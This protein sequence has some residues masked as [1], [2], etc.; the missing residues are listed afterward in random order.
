MGTI[1]DEVRYDIMRC[2]EMGAKYDSVIDRYSAYEDLERQKALEQE[3]EAAAAAELER[4]KEL[5]RQAE[6]KR[7]AEERSRKEYE[8]LWNRA[9]SGFA[10]SIGRQLGNS[11]LR[12][13][14][15]GKKK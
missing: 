8:R 5:R 3:L 10:S 12:G 9:S 13:I 6:E 4:Q 2:S 14:L 7:K 1:P 11:I 15:G